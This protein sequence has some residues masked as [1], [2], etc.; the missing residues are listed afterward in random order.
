MKRY[1][2]LLSLLLASVLTFGQTVYTDTPITG[3]GE[4]CF[5][6]KRKEVLEAIKHHTTE[7]TISKS[8]GDAI[9]AEN[10]ILAGICF[11]KCIF[12]FE[13][14]K[15]FNIYFQW[16]AK[17]K[18]DP[19]AFADILSVL[20]NDYGK[21]TEGKHSSD[22]KDT[23][24][25]WYD[26]SSYGK[27]TLNRTNYNTDNNL[28]TIT[29]TANNPEFANTEENYDRQDSE[30]LK[31]ESF[32]IRFGGGVSTLKG[33]KRS[34]IFENYKNISITDRFAYDIG[35]SGQ[36]GMKNNFFFMSEA[37]FGVLG[38]TLNLQ[39]KSYTVDY[40]SFQSCNYLGK[41]IYLGDKTSVFVALGL[42]IDLHLEHSTFGET[43]TP[44]Y[45]LEN[46][47]DF[48]FGGTLMAGIEYDRWQISANPQLG[49][50]DIS[51][52]KES[53]VYN[54]ALKLALTY[55]FIMF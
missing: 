2:I 35:F 29:L 10:V 4:F 1:S 46:F 25:W 52:D 16:E 19:E 40:G 13:K 20:E 18:N 51:R 43:K 47:K 15:L 28:Y 54:S 11:D 9:F 45:I 42:Y 23:W 3:L 7:Q 31:T 22:K 53:S 49:F 17:G 24:Y 55:K 8:T 6:M 39:G 36:S 27:I 30:Y 32:G 21:H 26:N 50:V 48:D 5:G 38:A 37:H 33:L 34:K 41:K 44:E 14:N 12:S